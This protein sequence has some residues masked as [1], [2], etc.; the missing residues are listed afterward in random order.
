MQQRYSYSSQRKEG[1]RE[2]PCLLIHTENTAATVGLT[3]SATHNVVESA[4]HQF[5][6][7]PCL[8]IGLKGRLSF[9]PR[10]SAL[11]TF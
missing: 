10:I 9:P 11:M 7:F 8:P 6:H 4:K 3:P 5:L 2:Q 1:K